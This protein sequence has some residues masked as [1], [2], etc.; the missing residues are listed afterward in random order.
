M[1]EQ[2]TN[3]ILKVAMES[4]KAYNV[5]ELQFQFDENSIFL[6]LKASKKQESIPEA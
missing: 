2:Q 5:T 3:E 1:D 6:S 4:L